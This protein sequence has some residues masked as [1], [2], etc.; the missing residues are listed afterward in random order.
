[1]LNLQINLFSVSTNSSPINS[2]DLGPSL[3][4][5]MKDIAVN[6]F[7]VTELLRNRKSHKATWLI[8][9]NPSNCKVVRVTTKQE[10]ISDS[11]II[12]GGTLEEAKSAKYFGLNLD[13]KVNFNTQCHVYACLEKAN[14]TLAFLGCNLYYCSRKIKEATY[15]IYVRPIL[16]YASAV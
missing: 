16:E 11:Y 12:H 13:N 5:P 9:F 6:I 15:K 10:P 2:P 1:M 7:S 8:Q 4:L 3:H 14:T